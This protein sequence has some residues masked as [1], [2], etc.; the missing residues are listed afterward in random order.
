MIFEN[1]T[2]TELDI[3]NQLKDEN[4]HDTL[5]VL[6]YFM[7]LVENHLDKSTV[8]ETDMMLYQFS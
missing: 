4:P 8:V 1:K 2:M 5:H 6:A 3:T 7:L